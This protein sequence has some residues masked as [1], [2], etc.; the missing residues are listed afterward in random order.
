MEGILPC[1]GQGGHSAAVEGVVQGEHR[2][3]ALPILVKGVLPGH[4]E[5]ALVALGAGVAEE[6]GC[7]PGAG[8]K[9]L[10]QVN[11]GLGV[12]Q[13]GDVGQ[14][15]R[16]LRHRRHPFGV[17]GAHRQNADAGGKV[18]VLLPVHAVESR[19]PAMVQGDGVSAVGLNHILTVPIFQFLKGHVALSFHSFSR[20]PMPASVSS[21]VRME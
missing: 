18:D 2:P 15:T 3:P 4:L 11:V 8:A 14:S 21:S 10:R 5:D 1:G 13:V 12:V 7:H 17:C 19:P 16:L 20:V 9:L 6:G